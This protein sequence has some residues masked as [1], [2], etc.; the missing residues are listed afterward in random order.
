MI[1]NKKTT[2]SL[3]ALSLIVLIGCQVS[4]TEAFT[5]C[6][7]DK[8]VAVYSTFWSEASNTQKDYFGR[9][10][11]DLTYYECDN[12]AQNSDTENCF[13]KKIDTFPTW[14]IPGKGIVPGVHTVREISE[15]TGC[16]LD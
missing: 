3:L 6:L 14:E 16:P 1:K 12:R 15:F 13:A 9:S 8:G 5:Q 10:F 11:R 7:N 4:S 2:M